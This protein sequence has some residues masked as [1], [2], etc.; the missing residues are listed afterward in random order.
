MI[1]MA[2]VETIADLPPGAHRHIIGKTPDEAKAELERQGASG[3]L[4]WYTN[5]RGFYVI[6]YA[7]CNA[8]EER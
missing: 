2:Q 6:L 4:H 5:G 7:L 1:K 3:D 8:E